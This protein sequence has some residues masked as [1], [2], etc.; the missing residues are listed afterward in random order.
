MNMCYYSFP[1]HEILAP[2]EP[3]PINRWGK[4]RGNL[5]GTAQGLDENQRIIGKEKPITFN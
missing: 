3:R 1:K 5:A 4:V 2:L